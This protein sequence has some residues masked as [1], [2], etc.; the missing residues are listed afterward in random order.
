MPRSL[1]KLSPNFVLK[2]SARKLETFESL[3]LVPENLKLFD[4]WHLSLGLFHYQETTQ[5]TFSKPR[6]SHCGGT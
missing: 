1:A 6:R 5:R 3:N 4:L 2:L